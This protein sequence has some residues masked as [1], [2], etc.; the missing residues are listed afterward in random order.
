M[1]MEDDQK[2][3]SRPQSHVND[4]VP[5]ESEAQPSDD[6]Q[7]YVYNY[8]AA[9][10]GL[11]E[12]SRYN[13]G[14]FHP[15]HMDDILNGRFEVVHKLGSGGFGTVWL[16][17]DRQL[18]KWRAVKVLTADHSSDSAEARVSEFLRENCT[19]EDL[20]QNHI[21]VPLESFWIEGPNGRHL[22]LVMQI[23]GYPVSDWRLD[24]DNIKPSTKEDST[25][26]CGQITQALA[27]LHS[28]GICHGDYRP[29]NILMKLDQD[30]LDELD[31]AQMEE[32]LGE[33]D[34]YGVNTKSGESP[35]PKGPEY[36]V[37]AV[38][39]TWCEKLLIPEIAVIDFGESF[40]IDNPSTATG[41]PTAYAAPEVLFNQASGGGVDLWSLACT[42]YEVRTR[43]KLFGGSFYGSK[44]STVVHEMEVILGPLAK[45]YREVWDSEDFWGPDCK[46]RCIEE[47]DNSESPATC[48]LASLQRER[49]EEI[50]GSGYDD[51][52]EAMLGAE[53]EQHHSLL[54]E[55]RFKPPIKYQYERE[56]VLALADLLKSLLKYSP[57]ERLEA[58]GVL[59]HP[60]LQNTAASQKMHSSSSSHELSWA[61]RLLSM[62]RNLRW[63]S[64]GLFC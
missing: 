49:S 39:S 20:N 15:I 64:W 38:T 40:F 8:L 3:E 7:E 43:D 28:K 18:E 25:E 44:L 51:I 46:P 19:L 32:L 41:I 22:C 35:L 31:Q 59:Q 24:L 2:T 58:E 34:S 23:Y 29:S 37:I 9:E 45:P 36:C 47:S 61:E 26:I 54:S 60:W 57:E 1:K 10:F 62:F 17:R 42:L 53:K 63:A 11:E 52:L 14:G 55:D 4:N 21:A 30:A 48:S 56:E 6:T 27:F 12:I 50:K 33:A 13:K 5:V 16:C